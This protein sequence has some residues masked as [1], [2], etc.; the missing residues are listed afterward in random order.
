VWP[1]FKGSLSY[2]LSRYSG[3]GQ[4]LGGAEGGM[5][6]RVL[7]LA[8]LGLGVL[9]GGMI[10]GWS[11]G[12]SNSGNSDW[13]LNGVFVQG[14]VG[15]GR[16]ALLIVDRALITPAPS[17]SYLR[18]SPWNN[19]LKSQLEY[20]ACHNSPAQLIAR[21]IIHRKYIAHADARLK[22]RQRLGVDAKSDRA[23][24]MIAMGVVFVFSFARQ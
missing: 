20:K 1:F 21:A 11:I 17:G 8:A 15:K 3:G 19:S 16:V 7:N 22:P 23:K 24:E 12:F 10:V 14:Q 9:L 13:T 6:K 2:S 18:Y 4:G 5:K